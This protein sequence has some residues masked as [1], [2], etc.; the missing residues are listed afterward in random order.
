[1]TDD[2]RMTTDRFYGGVSDRLQNLRSMLAY[3]HDE[4]PTRNELTHWVIKNTNAGSSDAVNRHLTFLDSLNII[5]LSSARCGLGNYGQQ[6]LD[7]HNHETLY[8]ALS[9]G[10]KGFDT[11]LKA[12][13]DGPMTDEE[14]MNLLVSE[15]NEA[16]MSKPGPAVRRREWLQVL[17]FVEREDG[18]NELTSAGQKR[19]EE[20]TQTQITSVGTAPSGVSVGDHL[21]QEEIEEAFETGFGYQI[22]GINPRRD[23]HDR[24][25][26]LVFAN[27]DGPYDDTVTQGQFEYIGEGLSGDQSETSPGNSTLIDAISSD[28]PVH[29]FYQQSGNGEWEY[30]GLIDVLDYEF[31]EQGGRQ[32][33]VFTME[34][35]YESGP[36]T[37][38]LSRKSIE[39]ERARLK[40]ALNREPQLTDDSETYTESR[41]RA[42]DSAFSELVRQAYDETCAICGSRRET[43]SGNP[44]V[45]AAHIYPKR[46]DGADDMRNGV[47]LCKLHHWAFDNGWLAISDEHEVLVKDAPNRDG[48][49]EF[50]QLKGDSLNLPDI[51][52]AE[53]RPLFLEQHRDSHGFNSK[54]HESE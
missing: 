18:M 12:L 4:H 5:E 38:E 43:P 2:C 33:L 22:T 35:R 42:R 45:E 28:I 32:V 17:E 8:E 47:A 6:W 23:D 30:Q 19:L 27:E 40:N 15:F 54:S 3:M 46:E 26:V 36:K 34:H 20:K 48:Y 14:I 21:S 44:E 41:R 53:P 1:M 9:S 31:E 25:Y 10:V 51:D 11:I 50:K 7:H 39:T 24:R 52:E 16:E 49:D 37:D 29:F 13:Q